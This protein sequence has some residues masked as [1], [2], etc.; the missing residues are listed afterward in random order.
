MGDQNTLCLLLSDLHF[1][2]E[3]DS[4]NIAVAE[5]R[6][7][8]I[9][10]MLSPASK[11]DHIS[12]ICD[13]DL[14]EGEGIWKSQ[15][16]ENEAPAI[17]QERA[18][19]HSLWGLCRGLHKRWP[20][21]LISATVI[22]GNHGRVNSYAHP[23]TN[24]DSAVGDRLA[25]LAHGKE[26]IKVGVARGL[27]VVLDVGGM[28]IAAMHRAEKHATTPALIGRVMRRLRYYKADLLVGAHWH[29]PAV[30]SLDGRPIYIT[31]GSLCGP[32]S[33]AEQIGVY[34]PPAQASWSVEGGQVGDVRWLKW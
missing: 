27:A 14:A 13:G 15:V 2:K 34:D 10:E 32:D 22:P 8:E 17:D 6:I 19:S 1:G 9:P 31:N 24:Y 12:L 21:A 11:P 7:A 26:W 28:R 20:R 25:L 30:Y 3:T 4:F 33:F 23:R 5:K 29:S 18:C 16:A